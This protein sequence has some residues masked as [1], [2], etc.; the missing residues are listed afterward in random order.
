MSAYLQ[1]QIG[2]FRQVYQL[3]GGAV[4]VLAAAVVGSIP[5]PSFAALVSSSPG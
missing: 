1:V 2:S 4:A 5:S 3:R